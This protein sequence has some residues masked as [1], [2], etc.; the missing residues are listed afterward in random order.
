MEKDTFNELMESLN[1]GLEIVKG[2][3]KPSRTFTFE[4]AQIKTIRERTGTSQETFAALINISAKTLKNWEQ[5][6]R[7]PTGPARV[8]LK[9]V[10]KDPKRI[11][12]LL[13]G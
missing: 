13:R 1:E 8:L 12:K 11:I 6:Q 7:T 4:P 10:E 5:G 2:N 9:L 3:M